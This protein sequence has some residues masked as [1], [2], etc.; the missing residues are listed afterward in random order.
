MTEDEGGGEGA[1]GK[2]TEK[3]RRECGD[4]RRE[5]KGRSLR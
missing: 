2:K 4:A 5:G 3:G 1:R